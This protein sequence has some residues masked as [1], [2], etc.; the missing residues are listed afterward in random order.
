MLS[1][2]E[3][4]VVVDR[5]NTT[6]HNTKHFQSDE[7]EDEDI[8]ETECVR[9]AWSVREFQRIRGTNMNYLCLF[10]YFHIDIFTLCLFYDVPTVIFFL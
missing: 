8:K 5:R 3:R 9:D 1:E 10:L 4:R 7:D 6:Q 2:R